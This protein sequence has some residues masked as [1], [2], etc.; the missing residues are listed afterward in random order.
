M[1]NLFL[2]ANVH[3]FIEVYILHYVLACQQ[4]YLFTSLEAHQANI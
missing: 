3:Q 2:T 1:D 4:F